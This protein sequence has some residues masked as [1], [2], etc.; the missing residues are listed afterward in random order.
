MSSFRIDSLLDP[1]LYADVGHDAFC[2]FFVSCYDIRRS[3]PYATFDRFHADYRYDRALVSAL[4]FL[5]AHG[6]IMFLDEALAAL[7]VG[8]DEDELDDCVRRTVEIVMKMKRA[9][10]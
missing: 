1:L 9:A 7:A 8:V 4:R 2:G 6:F 5:E 10:D 3:T